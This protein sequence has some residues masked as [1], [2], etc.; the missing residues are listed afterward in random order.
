MRRSWFVVVFG[1]ALSVVGIAA[2]QKTQAPEIPATPATIAAQAGLAP[3]NPLASDPPLGGSEMYTADTDFE[4]CDEVEVGSETA[5]ADGDR[6][7]K[8]RNWATYTPYPPS[9]PVVLFAGKHMNAGLVTLVDNGDDTLTI[10]I[11]LDA[12]WR[13]AEG[14]E[15]NLHIQHYDLEDGGVP[16]ESPSPGQFDY[17]SH[18]SSEFGGTAMAV[19]PV[20]DFYGI[21]AALENV[22]TCALRECADYSAFEPGD[23]IEGAGAVMPGLTID[24]VGT[25]VKISEGQ[26]PDVY[27][28]PNNGSCGVPPN[29][30]PTNGCLD[31]NGGFSDDV[32]ENAGGAHNFTFTF[33]SPV[34]EFT[35]RMLDYG[36][37]NP[38]LATDHLVEMTAYNG[39]VEVDTEVL[40]YTSEGVQNPRS[41]DPHGDMVCPVDGQDGG[42]GD[43]C[44]A[45]PGSPG[46]YV[47][48]VQSDDGISHVTLEFGV[49]HD[50]KT[51]FDHLCTTTYLTYTYE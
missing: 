40:S 23:S 12:R 4:L 20:A 18:E 31:L 48:E 10:T 41:S 46:N 45:P 25:A 33:D 37:Y 13:F 19:L 43:A 15:E 2:G 51:G 17:K 44:S 38:T 8:R 26:D 36:D 34:H 5:W 24:A 3:S 1:L 49:G 27:G 9:D 21:H 32:T 42:T 35:L 14:D 47:W 50:P 11:A 29:D 16:Q 30:F 22:V 28:A 6:Y 7:V 39:P